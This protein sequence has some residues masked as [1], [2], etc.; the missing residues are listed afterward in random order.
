DRVILSHQAI[1]VVHEALA[2]VLRVL[3]VLPD[4][5]RFYGADLLAH[6]A[7]DAAELI[8]FVNHRITVPLIVFARHEPDAVRRTNRGAK[9][10]RDTLRAAIRVLLHPVRAAPALVELRLLIRV[11]DRDFL[12]IREVLER[13]RHPTHGS[14]EVRSLVYRALHGFDVD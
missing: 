7:E 13:E 2:R 9:S 14:A 6:P 5:N 3:I 8:D 11:L 10:A 12:R 4:V 1:E